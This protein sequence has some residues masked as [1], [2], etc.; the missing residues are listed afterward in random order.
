MVCFQKA[1]VILSFGT[2]TLIKI[3]YQTYE[4]FN[5]LKSL[6]SFCIYQTW[7]LQL[8][9]LVNALVFKLLK[10][11]VFARLVILIKMLNSIDYLG[12]L[13]LKCQHAFL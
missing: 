13:C 12:I 4:K 6:H 8:N 7:T 2:Q 11:Y 10:Q 9:K 5:L 1:D 3:S